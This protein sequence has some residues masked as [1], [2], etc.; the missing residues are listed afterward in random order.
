MMQLWLNWQCITYVRNRQELGGK[1][2]LVSDSGPFQ[3]PRSCEHTDESVF[4]T[5]ISQ[6]LI[7][8]GTVL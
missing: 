5:E 2:D 6:Y 4:M 7:P 3:A 8:T 1:H